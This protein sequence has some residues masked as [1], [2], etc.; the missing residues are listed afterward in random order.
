MTVALYDDGLTSRER[1][2][3]VQGRYPVGPSLDAQKKDPEFAR[4]VSERW[5]QGN[6]TMRRARARYWINLAFYLAEQWIWW[7]DVRRM[8]M[9]VPQHYS[10]LGPGRVRLTVNRFGPNLQNVVARF[11][12]SELAFE[13]TP[14]SSPDSIVE[15]ARRGEAVLEAA[16]RNQ[17][18]ESLR[19]DAILAAFFGGTSGLS[20]EWD[21]GLGRPI[22]RDDATGRM[23]STGDVK[24][25]CHNVNEFCLEPNVKH[26]MDARYW[27]SGLALP[28]GYVRE[29]FDLDWMP[30]ADAH[31]SET[32]FRD[33]LLEQS[34]RLASRNLVLV[35]TYYER[36]TQ[37]SQGAYGCVVNGVTVHRSEWP[38]PFEG[39]NFTP[40]RQKPI[41]GQVLGA[42]LLDDAVPIQVAYNHAR[43]VLAEHM[44]L[45]GNSRLVA[46]FGS[47]NE[48]DVHDSA[49]SILYYMPD[50]GGSPP[51]YMSPPNLPRWLTQEA[52][53]LRSELDDVMHVHDISRGQGFSRASGQALSFLAEQD[54]SPFGPMVFEQKAGWE[55]VASQ[56]LQLFGSKVQETR[57]AKLRA[58][59]GIAQTTTWNGASLQ[60]QYDVVVP[61]EAVVPR[62]HAARAA[63]AKDLWDRKIITDPRVYARMVGL[64]PDEFDQLLD[65]DAAGA[66]RENL[67]MAM[68]YVEIPEPFDNNATHIAEHNRWR[69]S[70][71]Y[72]YADPEVRAI[73]DDH[74]Q[75]HEQRAHQEFAK[76]YARAQQGPAY[77]AL[78]QAD[79]PPGSD[80]P[81]PAAQQQAML[82][83]P[84]PTNG[85]SPPAL[86]ASGLPSM[87]TA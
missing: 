21:P 20:T 46:P 7:S 86:P 13:V 23:I 64:P 48:E 57:T 22:E 16:R 53:N 17:G 76:Q 79:E 52:E 44:K 60:G 11:L 35:L 40:F 37:K 26:Y 50:G 82:N 34:G 42:T 10:P 65:E 29:H 4:V 2:R 81:L 33:M 8:V 15:G 80:V 47:I 27:I 49:G 87:A 85:G 25:R 32:R 19:Y 66:N 6:D 5:Q 14:S 30:R 83:Q 24:V 77:P 61:L 41:D 73:F 28:A 3:P 75:F 58:A 71:A 70:D 39:L 51:S 1:D 45:A 62:T 36:P 68:G 84:Q 69:K 54:D 18:W 9:P 38:F 43:S 55:R 12:K 74:I 72:K 78:P 31:T 59:P 63:N 56:C 67:R